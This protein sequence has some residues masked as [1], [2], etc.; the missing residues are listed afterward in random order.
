VTTRIVNFFFPI[1]QRNP[2]ERH[3]PISR[4]ASKNRG[5]GAAHA[6][7]GVIAVFAAAQH[8]FN[9]GCGFLIVMAI[10]C[11]FISVKAR[12]FTATIFRQS[13]NACAARAILARCRSERAL[14]P[15]NRF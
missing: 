1:P 2:I 8:A 11:A 6:V 14:R 4:F 15:A 12:R 10:I 7:I 9:K 13:V 5:E 3:A